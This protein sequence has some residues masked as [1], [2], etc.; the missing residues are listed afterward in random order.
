[1]VAESFRRLASKQ[2]SKLNA[3]SSRKLEI[4]ISIVAASE[5]SSSVEFSLKAAAI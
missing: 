4:A 5:H 1:V 3:S 2:S